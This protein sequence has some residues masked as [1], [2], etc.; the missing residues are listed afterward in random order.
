MTGLMRTATWVAMAVLC[1]ASAA[2]Q[3][4]LSDAQKQQLA[5]AQK[6]LSNAKVNFDGANGARGKLAMVR[7]DQAKSNVQAGQAILAKLPAD[8]AEVA[9]TAQQLADME[10]AIAELE[11]K[12]RGG[13]AAPADNPDGV[14][15]N[16]EQEKFLKDGNYYLREL[17][18]WAGGLEDLVTK[19]NAA[20]DKDL[21][22]HRV[23]VNAMATI[24]KARQR[25]GFIA[26]NLAKLPADGRGVPALAE[27]LAKATARVDAAEKALAPV[28]ARLQEI[29][30]PATYPQLQADI[31]RLGELS[32]MYN[33]PTVFQSD[34]TRA[35]E[36]IKQSAAARAE[37][38]RVAEAYKLLM[39]QQTEL[40]KRVQGAVNG[41]IHNYKAFGEAAMAYKAEL[42]GL[43]D[44]HLAETTKLADEAVAEQKPAFFQGGIPQQLD[45]AREKIEVLAVLDADAAAAAQAKFDATVA[46][47]REKESGLRELIVTTNPLPPDRYAGADRAALE[48]KAVETWKAVQPDAQVLAIRFPAEAWE[49]RTTWQL[50]HTT[51]Y[52]EDISR[53]Q[54]QLILKHDDRLAVIRP[55]NLRMNHDKGDTITAFPMDELKDELIPA[56]FLLLD[57]VK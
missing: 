17:D 21:L 42:P 19:M 47:L 56:R 48:A 1:L 46:S 51:W 33:N 14:K 10:L 22:D 11:A 9:A 40:G 38:M 24:E 41:F 44:A 54:A 26:D 5:S 36:P 45:F 27:G 49:R 3:A 18:G 6:Q 39:A 2:T 7:A 34:P 15:L 31:T 30:N 23:F 29:I 35:I 37:M 57:K 28:H 25:Q 20:E 52:R 8:D 12:L 16:Y 32:G 50:I 43:I 55:I 53:L 13:T 4:E